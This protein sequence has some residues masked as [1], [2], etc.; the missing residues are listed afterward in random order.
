M[1][2]AMR[3]IALLLL[4]WA[5]PPARDPALWPFS[6]D[7]PWNTPLASDARFAAADDPTT[8]DLTDPAVAADINC[9]EWSVPV[10]VASP[11]DPWLALSV[12]PALALPNGLDAS[13]H[14][15]NPVPGLRAPRDAAPGAPAYGAVSYTDGHTALIDETHSY[16]VEMWRAQRRGADAMAAY[17]MVRNDLRGPGVGTGGARAYGGSAIGG[18]IR[19]GELARG[20]PHALAFA[21]PRSKQRC[22]EP[23]WPATT[24]DGGARGSYRGHVPMGQLAAIPPN[25]DIAALGLSPQG[26]AI[27]RALQNYGAYDVDS[28][29][30]FSIYA[31]PAAAAELGR[32]KED[33]RKI[34]PLLRCVLDNLPGTPGGAPPGA[35]RR[36]PAAPPLAG[37]AAAN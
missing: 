32:A 6:S 19:K 16:V 23:V 8:R 14:R 18:L 5:A 34:R 12:D 9:R 22:C 29:S 37:P 30:D 4:L 20:I 1:L 33:L 26:L 3:L 7:S 28:S 17:T 2:E 10:Y 36:A 25:V 35:R 31:E 11:G 15:N 13:I 24:V 21:I 27:A